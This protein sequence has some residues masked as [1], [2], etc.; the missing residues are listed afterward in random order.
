M[1]EPTSSFWSSDDHM[2]VS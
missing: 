1:V 2:I